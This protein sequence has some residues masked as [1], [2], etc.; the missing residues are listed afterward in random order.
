MAAHRFE[1][2]AA[3]GPS[4]HSVIGRRAILQV[5]VRLFDGPGVDGAT[6]EQDVYT[7]L[8]P[9]DARELAARLIECAQQ[10]EEITEQAG[11]WQR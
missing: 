11:W 3:A 9:R 10:A 2:D 7:D 1:I 5:R 4:R 6:G 8:L